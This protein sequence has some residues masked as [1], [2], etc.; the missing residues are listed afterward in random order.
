M[1]KKLPDSSKK[2]HSN[3][4]LNLLEKK[5]SDIMPIWVSLQLE[6]MNSVY[7]TFHD[8]EKFMIVIYLIQRTFNFNSKDF[9]KL[10]YNDFLNQDFIEIKKFNIIEISTALNIPKE[11]TRRKINELEKIGIINRIK[12]KIVLNKSS[13]TTLNLEEIIKIMSRSSTIFLKILYNEKIISNQFA[14]E[15][16]KIVAKENFFDVW[17]LYYNMQIQFLLNFKVVFKNLELFHVNAVCITNQFLNSKQQDNSKMSKAYFLDKYFFTKQIIISGIN[18]MSISDITG[19]P[20][21]TVTRKLEKLVKEK[22]L[23]IDKKKHYTVSG[24]HKKKMI[25][26]QKKNF[27]NISIFIA[28]V[29]NLMIFKETNKKDEKHLFN[30]KS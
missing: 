15:N 23:K 28:H 14:S 10:T 26:T 24:F 19:I 3:I 6:W 27:N 16:I 29:C 30:L 12:K 8:Y 5:Y 1:L 22:Y 11:S 18:A 17:K 25:L 4:I 20:R 13:W 21:A 9:V 7:K 2:I